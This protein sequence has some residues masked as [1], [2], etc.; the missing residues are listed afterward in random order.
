M[1]YEKIIPTAKAEIQKSPEDREDRRPQVRD[2][3]HRDTFSQLDQLNRQRQPR[4][5]EDLYRN[6]EGSRTEHY[7]HSS[8]K[9]TAGACDSKGTENGRHSTASAH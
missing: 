9:A 6:Q 2:P 8:S 5:A 1:E 7:R 3:E 4:R